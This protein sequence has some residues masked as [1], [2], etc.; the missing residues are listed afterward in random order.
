MKPTED[1]GSTSVEVAV[2]T[3]VV[4]LVL[5]LLVAGGRI[6]TA[7]A[8]VDT[9][10][11]TAARAASIARTAPAA[12]Q[13]AATTAEAGL[14]EHALHCAHHEVTL[15]SSGFD[16]PAGRPGTVVVHAA[17]TVALADLALPG[18]PGSIPL[19]AQAAS[20]LDPYRERP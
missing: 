13:H 15:D 12:Q 14:R 7:H 4:L 2:L 19:Q 20:P 17:C 8:A 16:Q 9:A 18:M 10:A 5:A 3:P 1:T 11:T 6:V